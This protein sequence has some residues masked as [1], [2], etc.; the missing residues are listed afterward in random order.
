MFSEEGLH[1][2]ACPQQNALPSSA[3]TTI[4]IKSS[5]ELSSGNQLNATPEVSA[6][7]APGGADSILTSDS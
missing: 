2:F 6:H 1:S 3:H 5:F 7:D 4:L